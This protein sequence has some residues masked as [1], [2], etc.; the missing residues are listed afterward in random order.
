M[1]PTRT[2]RAQDLVQAAEAVHQDIEGDG[3]R[4]RDRMLV[5][6]GYGTAEPGPPGDERH[7]H[8]FALRAISS[9]TGMIIIWKSS[10]K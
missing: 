3:H 2:T 7:L 4:I 5:F 9:M 10:E 1:L 8:S 6:R